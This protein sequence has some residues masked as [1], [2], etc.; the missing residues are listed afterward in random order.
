M[1][2]VEHRFASMGGTAR[3]TL[4]SAGHDQPVLERHAAA[5]RGII[6]DVEAALS[7]FRPDSERTP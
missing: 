1:I 4:E 3:V 7:R 2:R 5:L 6:E